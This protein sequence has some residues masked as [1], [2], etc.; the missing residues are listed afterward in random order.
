MF[1]R[2]C[3]EKDVKSGYVEG[4]NILFDI[5]SAQGR[6]DLVARSLPRS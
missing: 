5:R 4:Q 3:R 6:L 1:G 2:K